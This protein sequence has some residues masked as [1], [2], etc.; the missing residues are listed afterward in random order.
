MD[1]APQPAPTSSPKSGA[2]SDELTP[3]QKNIIGGVVGSVAGIALLALLVMLAMRYKRRRD[4]GGVLGG[5]QSGT[6]ASRSIVGGDGGSAA[7]RAMTERSGPS[8][9]VAAALASL[10]AGNRRTR[11]SA[12][13]VE[14]GER[15]FYRVS[16]RK[17]PSVL[18]SG[19]DG[20]SDPRGSTL[21]GSS[22]YFRGSQAFDRTAVQTGHLALGAPMRP[23]S[24]VPVM[25]SGPA[26]IP[27]TENPFADPPVS[28][29]ATHDVAGRNLGT[30]DSP[31]AP[32]SRFQESI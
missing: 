27:I 2:S 3:Q 1:G 30:R 13:S 8:T 20:Y 12:G 15:G 17:L 4:G 29:G 22:D 6:T 26:R 5:G 10:V 31:R 7:S 9:A 11:Q 14:G 18:Q 16:G 21:S 25:R 24:G 28:P 32:G 23:V 19:G